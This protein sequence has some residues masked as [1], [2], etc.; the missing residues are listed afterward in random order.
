[1]IK[2]F[3]LVLALFI[4]ASVFAQTPEKLS[5]QAVIRDSGDNLVADQMVGMQ[6]SILQ[7]SASGT[8]VYAE[9]HTASTNINGLLSVE[10]GSGTVT[11]G[12]FA[13]IDWAVG[14]YFIK[15]ET[16]PTGGSSYSI[17]G[18]SQLLSVPYA[19]YAK[20]AESMP[21]ATTTEDGALSSE[22][23]IKL[24]AIGL[25]TQEGQMM[26]WDGT[27][28]V[29]V[30]PTANE[31]ATLQMIGGVPTWVGG[32]EP[33]PDNVPT[34]YN[35]ITGRTWMDRN[36][37]ASQVATSS[38]DADAYGDLYQWGRSADGHQLRTAGSTTTVT[39]ADNPGHSDFIRN[40]T[41][42]FDWHIPQND[43]L[44]QGTNAMN[45]PCPTG[46]RIP[47]IAEWEEERLSWSSNNAAGA[48]GSPLK[49]TTNGRRSSHSGDFF[50]VGAIG[51]YWSSTID[52]TAAKSLFFF[53][54]VAGPGVYN[55]AYGFAVRCIQDY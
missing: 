38:T 29:T 1:M 45:D 47:T 17:T 10:I 20:T 37:G 26:Y 46:F 55:R 51:Y 19:L 41:S 40:P 8:T 23:Q 32:T 36:L 28:W 31:G 13:S 30:E 7:G 12:D 50:E 53:S 27:A 11:S 44:W 34:V 3:T 33:E 18:T 35:P 15:T 42:P 24:N 25:G 22:D 16:D 21:L 14:P 48:F 6:V 5:Y 39:D 49:L 2:T 43:N 4:S 9:T 54:A 52:E